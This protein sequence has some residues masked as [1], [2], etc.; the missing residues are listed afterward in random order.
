MSEID[1]EQKPSRRLWLFA[2][3]AALAL[4]LG[5]AALA[6]AHLRNV[7]DDDSL[8]APAIEIGLELA[9]TK[10]EQTDLPP[11][12]E[13][14]ESVASPALPEQKAEVKE[15][16]L[17]KDTPTEE[18]EA[19]RMVTPNIVKKPIEEEEKVAKVETQASQELVQSEATAAPAL[20]NAPKAAAVGRPRHRHRRVGPA[21]PCHVGKGVDGAFQPAQALSQRA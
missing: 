12:P 11:G 13:Q 19:D 4:H 6:V 2:A 18:A 15:T 10:S 5:G 9:S 16:D 3:V 1:L 7:D 17:P 20:D 8:G 21:R 14:D